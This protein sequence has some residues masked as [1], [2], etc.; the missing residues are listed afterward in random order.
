MGR[1]FK[2]FEKK[3]MAKKIIDELIAM[4]S[5]NLNDNETQPIQWPS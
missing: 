3:L 5:F 2:Y 1:F 4:K